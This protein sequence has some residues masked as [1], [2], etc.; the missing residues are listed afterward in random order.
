MQLN[1]NLAGITEQRDNGTTEQRNKITKMSDIFIQSLVDEWDIIRHDICTFTLNLNTNAATETGENPIL[2]PTKCQEM[3]LRL[4]NYASR[5]EAA[6]QQQTQTSLT[7]PAYFHIIEHT[8][9]LYALARDC[10]YNFAV[11]LNYFE[12]LNK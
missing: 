7:N 12:E 10:D 2:T 6:R 8:R 11:F 9:K 1:Y 3:W 5:L 4:E